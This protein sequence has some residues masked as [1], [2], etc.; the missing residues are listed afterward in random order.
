MYL[1]KRKKKKQ[2]LWDSEKY[3]PKTWYQKPKKNIKNKIMISCS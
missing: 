3:A 2:R 1:K